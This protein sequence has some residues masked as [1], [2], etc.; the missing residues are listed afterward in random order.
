MKPLDD[1]HSKLPYER[2]L[3]AVPFV[4]LRQEGKSFSAMKP[5]EG[6]RFAANKTEEESGIEVLEQVVDKPKEERDESFF[7]SGTCDINSAS[8][9]ETNRNCNDIYASS[10]ETE[11]NCDETS[12]ETNQNSNE[13]E[14]KHGTNNY[15]TYEKPRI[16]SSI[17]EETNPFSCEE[18]NG[19]CAKTNEDGAKNDAESMCGTPIGVDYRELSRNELMFIR[20]SADAEKCSLDHSMNDHEKAV[21]KNSSL[22]ST[23]NDQKDGTNRNSYKNALANLQEKFEN[24]RKD[25]NEKGNRSKYLYEQIIQTNKSKG[26]NVAESPTGVDCREFIRNELMKIRSHSS[27]AVEDTSLD[28]SMDDQ[29]KTV[30]NSSL[31]STKNDQT[32]GTSINSYQNGLANFQEKFENARKDL[33]EQRNRNKYLC[34]QIMQRNK[35]KDLNEKINKREDLNEQKNRKDSSLNEQLNSPNAQHEPCEF[36]MQT[37]EDPFL[38]ISVPSAIHS[39]KPPLQGIIISNPVG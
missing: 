2:L 22:D 21:N 25:L 11:A 39:H 31:D 17:Y 7:G 14:L 13:T 12:N 32:D 1:G 19:D 26:L 34:E 36:A 24:A 35:I 27:A 18:T 10:N 15:S 37:L 9:S 3:V 5:K 28:L 4:K 6:A 33:N 16:D 8:S 30:K 38:I 23:E 20:A 29:E